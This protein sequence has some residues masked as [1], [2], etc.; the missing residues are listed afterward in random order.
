M[1]KNKTY[2]ASSGITLKRPNVSDNNR[3]YIYGL[4][5]NKNG[6]IK[7]PEIMATSSDIIYVELIEEQ[8]AEGYANLPTSL[9]L[10]L[11]Y[12]GE[13]KLAERKGEDGVYNELEGPKYW[14]I[15]K[16]NNLK[17]QLKNE[18]VIGISI[19]DDATT[20][21][22]REN[23][24]KYEKTSETVIV[25]AVG[26]EFTATFSQSGSDTEVQYGKSDSNGNVRFYY[27]NKYTGDLAVYYPE[28]KDK[29]V[30]VI[31]EEMPSENYVVAAKRK[32][33][34]EFD[35]STKTWKIKASYEFNEEKE[36][37]EEK[38]D[39][40]SQSYPNGNITHEKLDDIENTVKITS[41]TLEKK[42]P[43]DSK[44]NM[45]G[46]TFEISLTNVS[47]INGNPYNGEAKT[48][49]VENGVIKLENLEVIDASK[50]VKI[51]AKET[52][53]PERDGY[54][55]KPIDGNIEIT[56]TREN[57]EYSI[58]SVD[59]PESNTGY[60]IVPSSGIEGNKVS[61]VVNNV[62]YISLSG[63]VWID[64]QIG[65]KA[66]IG[67]NGEKD[68]GNY[69][70]G[71]DVH[72]YSIK[73]NK[74]IAT[75][76]TKDNGE[77]SFEDVVKTAEGYKI[78]FEYNGILYEE[79]YE[80]NLELPEHG[81]VKY[82]WGNVSAIDRQTGLVV[83]KPSGVD[84]ATM[85]A[86]DMVVVDLDGNVVEGKWKPS[87]DTATHVELYKAFP[88]IGGITHTHSINA[89]SFA[90]AG[91]PIYALGT[92]HADAFY[93]DIPCT[94]AL[95]KDEIE[96]AY[97]KN[98][99]KVIIETINELGYGVMERPGIVVRNHGPFTWGKDAAGAL[100]RRPERFS[101]E[102]G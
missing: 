83:I 45:D 7:I 92:T 90:Q 17:V 14:T 64:G 53:V 80:A 6:E 77:Y 23:I 100:R 57:G 52:A 10:V 91:M 48:C 5:I 2:T 62:A 59:Y 36:E 82:T 61:F 37:Y 1:T 101:W 87:S 49:T 24:T 70:N 69:L 97:E 50:E 96:E 76:Q 16:E 40:I 46:T 88:A 32:Y 33:I 18:E 26:V 13:W 47:K 9:K 41:I 51:I 85:T 3:V 25:P 86:E 20:K 34:F 63:Q 31:I 71:I 44:A 27:N 21:D 30:S 39:S 29:E 89:V 4:T 65:D 54:Y 75:K 8:P 93:G 35:E 42:D 22:V 98:T 66:V 84:Y 38:E 11:R 72:L 67:A 56:L 79:V 81:L 55:Y 95:T 60:K 102:T 74:I 73:D 99:G 19:N 43:G 68:D 58:S 78:Q 94:R 15:D 12:D 28:T